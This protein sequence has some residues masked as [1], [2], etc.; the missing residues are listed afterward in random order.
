[1]GI[2]QYVP[3]INQQYNLLSKIWQRDTEGGYV[4][5]PWIDG[6]SGENRKAN[7]HSG[8]AFEWPPTPENATK[9]RIIAHLKAHQNDDI[10]F[11]PSLFM[12]P[13]RSTTYVAEERALWADLDEVHPDDI[14]PKYE[15]T[16]VWETSPGRYQAVWLFTVMNVGASDYGRENHRLT[17]FLGADPS[18]WDS[19]Q[20]LR[21]P[22]TRNHK[23]ENIGEDGKGWQ[24]SVFRDEE[25]GHEVHRQDWD[26]F[27]DLPEV[28]GG[29]VEIDSELESL[30]EDI[31]PERVIARVNRKLPR[32]VKSFLK[33]QDPGDND[34]SAIAWQIAR[35]L[36]DAG[37]TLAEI[38][39][40]VRGT[41]WNKYVGR[42]DELKRLK[43]EAAKAISQRVDQNKQTHEIAPKEWGELQGFHEW[44]RISTPP[45]AWLIRD[46]WLEGGL[47]FISGVPKSYKSW[48]GM[49]LVLAVATGCDFLGRKVVNGKR[50]AMYIQEEDGEMIVRD[51]M[52]QMIDTLCP[53][54]HWYGQMQYD[55]ES[56]FWD[57]PGE[58][59][60]LEVRLQSGFI[61][62]DPDWLVKLEEFVT[63][64]HIEFLLIDTMMTVSGDIKINDASELR[65]TMLNPLKELARQHGLAICFIHHNTK[66]ADLPAKPGQPLEITRASTRMMGS[67]QFHAWADCGIYVRDKRGLDIILEV[68]NKSQADKVFKVRIDQEDV[69]RFTWK[70]RVLPNFQA[71]T[72]SEQRETVDQVAKGDLKP[73]P[74]I[75]TKRLKTMGATKDNPILLKELVKRFSLNPV[76]AYRQIELEVKR[77]YVGKIPAT[78]TRLTSRGARFEVNAKYYL[79]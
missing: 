77:G 59:P 56:L 18:G 7:F 58:S 40:V 78:E 10:Y 57:P 44:G 68:E 64:H 72:T 38:I 20:L 24:G 23:P 12:E 76:N 41:V 55:G 26:D 39:V 13:E 54:M 25:V 61:A 49:N 51:R 46:F 15:P 29:K 50:R 42:N 11:T 1:M 79:L 73:K 37:C 70:P 31:K 5:L 36:A 19:T 16:L 45:T 27:A 33:A 43:I 17:Y 60:F 8:P 32:H 71:E 35:E 21:V 63:Q 75:T 6:K 28:P 67:G 47:G 65:S 62:S 66:A 48:F 22:G 30:L 3:S 2:I 34:R 69:D 53:D 9:A 4:F 74:G 14:P 52:S